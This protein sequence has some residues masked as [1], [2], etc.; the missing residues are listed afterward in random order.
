M[1]FCFVVFHTYL[2]YNDYTTNETVKRQ[3]VMGFLELKLAFMSKW[4]TARLEKKPFKPSGKSID[5]YEV[6]GDI[7]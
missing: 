2:I 7:E 4:E 5:K 6:R 1:L 3:S